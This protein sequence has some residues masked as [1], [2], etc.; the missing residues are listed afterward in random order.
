MKECGKSIELVA[1]ASRRPDGRAECPPDCGCCHPSWRKQ[2]EVIV[3]IYASCRASLGRTA[4]GGCSHVVC[5]SSASK[6]RRERQHQD[7]HDN[8]IH[9]KWDKP[10]LSHPSHEKRHR[11]IGDQV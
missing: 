7:S 11:R 4:E 10:T 9:R 5:G 2:K 3:L 1:P 6:S 8:P